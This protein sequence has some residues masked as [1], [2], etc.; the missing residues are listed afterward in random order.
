M[1]KPTPTPC[2]E[3]VDQQHLQ[4]SSKLDLDSFSVHSLTDGTSPPLRLLD[5]EIDNN[6]GN[7]CED[8]INKIWDPV[9]E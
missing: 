4:R 7:S 3:A 9:A 8:R 5:H 6:E 2:D 1:M